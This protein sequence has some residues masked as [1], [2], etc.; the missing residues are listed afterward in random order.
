MFISYAD[1]VGGENAHQAE[2]QAL[3][4]LMQILQRQ[5]SEDAFLHDLA[6]LASGEMEGI[7]NLEALPED[8]VQNIQSDLSGVPQ[9][10][11]SAIRTV[12]ENFPKSEARLYADMLLSVGASV[13]QA[14]DEKDDFFT[15]GNPVVDAV[16]F[17]TNARPIYHRI[18]MLFSKLHE[19]ENAKYLYDENDIFDQIKISTK[20]SDALA[21][22]SAAVRKAWLEK[23]PADAN[24]SV[25]DYL[26]EA[27]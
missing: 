16:T 18:L 9:E 14:Y 21:L 22:L 26:K 2:M 3:H 5:N 25:Q 10:V 11:E 15:T 24:Q 6:K 1:L 20:E 13:A 12:L 7:E 23:Y 27:K 8:A 19:D 17:V 4:M